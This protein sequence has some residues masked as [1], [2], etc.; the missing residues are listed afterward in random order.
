MATELVSSTAFGEAVREALVRSPCHNLRANTMDLMAN[1]AAFDRALAAEERMNIG[2]D[3]H[4][5]G[6]AISL[7]TVMVSSL[8]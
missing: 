3:R 4:E 5:D 2:D 6:S 8:V 7:T 1:L